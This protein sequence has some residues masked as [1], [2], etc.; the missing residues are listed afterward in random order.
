MDWP[1]LVFALKR[2]G[3][4]QSDIARAAGVYASTVYGWMNLG[5]IPRKGSK[6]VLLKMMNNRDSEEA[7]RRP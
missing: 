6:E 4:S 5:R 1:D 3:I 2:R 7:G